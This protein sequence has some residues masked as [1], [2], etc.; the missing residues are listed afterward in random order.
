MTNR[1][2]IKYAVIGVI[3]GIILGLFLITAAYAKVDKITWCHTEPNG[4]SQTLEL[5][6]QA[7]EQAGHMNAQGSP[8]HAGDHI[9]ACV[10]PTPTPCDREVTPEPTVTVAPT[11]TPTVEPT[12]VPSPTEE[13]KS[14]GWSP[15]PENPNDGRSDGGRSSDFEAKEHPIPS[16][17]VAGNC[18]NK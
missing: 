1:N 10:E 5:P 2:R 7:L 16:C 15:Q 6:Q 13:P 9:G 3:T 12:K 4:N 17:K 14:G 18:I 8:L 11:V